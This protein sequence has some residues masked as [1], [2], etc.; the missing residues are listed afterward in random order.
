[1]GDVRC[2]DCNSRINFFEQVCESCGEFPTLFYPYNW[3][4]D[5]DSVDLITVRDVYHA[6][7]EDPDVVPEWNSIW[8]SHLVFIEFC[9]GQNEAA[10]YHANECLKLQQKV[11]PNK[12]G[13]IQAV[14]QKALLCV[15]EN[16]LIEA[17][18]LFKKA[19]NMSQNIGY[20]EGVAGSKNFLQRFCDE[21]S[22]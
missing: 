6:Q 18:T 5:K 2:G 17:E 1:M 10:R 9:L 20:E 12:I 16:E 4:E 11:N 3:P 13:E 19:L 15:K 21:K 7:L 22:D 8:H 14:V